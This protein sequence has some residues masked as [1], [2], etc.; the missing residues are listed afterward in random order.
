[1]GCGTKSCRRWH[2]FATTANAAAATTTTCGSFVCLSSKRG[3]GQ[4]SAAMKMLWSPSS[5]RRSFRFCATLS[6]TRAC[7]PSP[8]P[9]SPSPTIADAAG[10]QEEVAALQSCAVAV[11]FAHNFVEVWQWGG[12]RSTGRRRG[13]PSAPT[14]WPARTPWSS[15]ASPSTARP[16]RPSESRRAPSSAS[17]SFG[18]A[19]FLLRG[20]RGQTQRAAAAEAAASTASLRWSRGKWWL[21]WMATRGRVSSDLEQ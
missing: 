10:S 5:S 4:H 13:R 7:S 6:S 9:P 11:G 20:T 15:R 18:T 21:A 14:A 16:W 1:M 17:W 8:P 19:S 3:R 12:Q 2:C